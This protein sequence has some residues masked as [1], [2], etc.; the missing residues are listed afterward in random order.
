MPRYLPGIEQV[1]FNSRLAFEML[2][3]RLR[4][5]EV[6]RAQ[7]VRT[8]AFKQRKYEIIRALDALTVLEMKDYSGKLEARFQRRVHRKTWAKSYQTTEVLL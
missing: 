6:L 3:D 4:D 8:V 7:K 1:Q 5:F 2:R